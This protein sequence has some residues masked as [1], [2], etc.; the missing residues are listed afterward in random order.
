MKKGNQF[1]DFFQKFLIDL[2][3]SRLLICEIVFVGNF[4]KR[5]YKVK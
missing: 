1:S 2:S 4:K 5:L 3:I